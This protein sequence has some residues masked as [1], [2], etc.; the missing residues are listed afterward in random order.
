MFYTVEESK[1]FK[2]VI[3]L[4]LKKLTVGMMI[5]LLSAGILVGCGA[6][7]EEPVTEDPATEDPAT[8]EP[9]SGDP[10][11]EDPETEDPAEPDEEEEAE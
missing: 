2:E 5:A 4:K 3:R 9:A 11:T 6:E 7:E 1:F 10:A 8:E